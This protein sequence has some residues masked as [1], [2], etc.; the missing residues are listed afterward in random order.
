[1]PATSGPKRPAAGSLMEAVSSRSNL[2]RAL[3]RVRK[4]GGSPGIDGMTV[5]ELPDWLRRHWPRVR[6]ELHAG[7]YRP[8]PVRRVSIPKPDGGSREL[9]IPT[10]LDRLIQQALLQVLQPEFDPSFSEHSHG[11]RPGRRAHDAIREARDRIQAG[12]QWVVDVDIEKFFDRVHHDVLMAKLARRIEDRSVLRLIRRYLD[13]GVMVNGVVTERYK[14]TPQGGPLSPLLANVYLDD[15]DKELERRGH[16]FVRY[17]DDLRVFVRSERAGMRVMNS[18][19]R[20]FAKLHLRVNP[21]KSA[22]DLAWERPF[23]GF[24]FWLKSDGRTRLRISGKALDRMK[25]KVRR[26]TRR[27]RGQSIETVVADLRTYL[28]GWKQYFRNSCCLP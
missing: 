1:M 10:V 26:I 28:P 19:A 11:F 7:R 25:T 20:L 15:I 8:Q 22:V 24:G 2:Q 21:A 17:A 14:G 5:D 4:N 23:L 18:L 3:K 16:A 6:E 13:T 9:G 27:N 12:N